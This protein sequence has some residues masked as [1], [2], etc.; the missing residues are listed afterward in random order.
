MTKLGVVAAAKPRRLPRSFCASATPA[1]EGVDPALALAA[2]R[3]RA[4][5]K[6]GSGGAGG[7]GG[8]GGNG[9]R[10]ALVTLGVL[11]VIGSFGV[12]PYYLQKRN[13]RLVR[14]H[15]SS[16]FCSVVVVPNN[17]KLLCFFCRVAALALCVCVACP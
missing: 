16:T 2:A 1:A 10:N 11:G 3:A 15:R 5:R 6:G 14:L 8:K 17:T 9:V 13:E 4:A 7:K 12:L